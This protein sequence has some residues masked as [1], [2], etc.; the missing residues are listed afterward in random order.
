MTRFL[1]WLRDA[2]RGYMTRVA[3]LLNKLSRGKLTPTMITWTGLLMHIP[4]AYLIATGHFLAAAV[5]LVV[6]GL[7]DALDGALARVQGRADA[8]G[9]LLDATTDR[10]KEVML[11]VGSAWVLSGMGDPHHAVWAVAACGASLLVSYVKAKGEMAVR[12][13]KLTPNEINRLFSDGFMRFEIRMAILA[14]GLATH[15][16]YFALVA[17]AEASVMTALMRLYRI[18]NYLRTHA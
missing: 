10:M 6:F 18:T 16:L 4:T 3:R 11:Y 12:A 13:R 17:I 1:D 7:F 15:F 2:V 5:L 14:L 9:M 8:A